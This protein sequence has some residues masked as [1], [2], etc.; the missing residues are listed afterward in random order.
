MPRQ[1]HVFIQAV[2]VLLDM[3]TATG[4]SGQLLVAAT[5][6]AILWNCCLVYSLAVSRSADHIHVF[7]F[8]P[9]IEEA[10]AA[11]KAKEAEVEDL[12]QKMAEG[13]SEAQVLSTCYVERCSAA[14]S[15]PVHD[16]ANPTGIVPLQR[17]WRPAVMP[18]PALMVPQPILDTGIHPI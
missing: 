6:C 8:C 1:V 2:N 11:L 10:Q 4:S 14:R 7:V 5:S 16:S 3:S 15:C 18:T 9:Q 12:K 17:H 13:L